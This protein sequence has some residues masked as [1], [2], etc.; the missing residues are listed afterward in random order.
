MIAPKMYRKK[1]G[2]VLTSVVVFV[3]FGLSVIALSAVLMV[4]NMQN[5]LKYTESG[6]C[7]NH[8][9]AGVEEAV[10][11]LLRD[12]TYSGGTMLLE[13]VTTTVTVSG[14]DTDKSILAVATYNGFAKKVLATVSLAGDKVSLLSWKEVI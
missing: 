10:L 11:R 2:Q 5:T 4:I 7:L 9:E 12:P 6:N 8:A 13:G 1:S 3:A 14:T